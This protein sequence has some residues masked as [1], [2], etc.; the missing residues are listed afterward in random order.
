M[1]SL[2]IRHSPPL[3]GILLG[4]ELS[5]HSPVFNT[6]GICN[7][8]S[9]RPRNKFWGLAAAYEVREEVDRSAT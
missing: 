1:P 5:L 6:A 9:Q 2:G 4:E 8:L 7:N 3:L